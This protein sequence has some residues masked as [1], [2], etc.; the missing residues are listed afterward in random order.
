MSS[1]TSESPGIVVVLAHPDDESFGM[2]GTLAKYA[3]G[4]ARVV[5]ICATLGEAGI[6]NMAPAEAARIRKAELDAATRTLGIAEVH[7]L[8]YMDGQVAAVDDAGAVNAISD[9]LVQLR[10]QA[11]ITFGPDGITGHPDHVAVHRFTTSAFDR[12]ASTET[13]REDQPVRLFYLAPSDATQQ[14]CGAPAAT[15][16]A[17]APVAGIDISE[18]LVTKVRAAQCHISQDPPFAGEPEVLAEQLVCHEYFSLAR[19]V[20]D[21]PVSLDDLFGTLPAQEGILSTPA[22]AGVLIRAS[23][24]LDISSM[25]VESS[26][27]ESR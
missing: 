14:G 10:P 27:G 16:Q 18:H 8:G 7:L 24:F 5:L 2:G 19:P 23:I 21:E 3:A 17:N 25:M 6:E 26:S 13:H 20:I 9:L 22:L 1:I 11:V 4:G 12:Y 15:R